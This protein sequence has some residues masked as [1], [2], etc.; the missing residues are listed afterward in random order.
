MV[1]M[2][3][4]DLFTIIPISSSYIYIYIYIYMDSGLK[5]FSIE[6]KNIRNGSDEEIMTVRS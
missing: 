1:I 3:A 5:G 2:Y 4:Y 6:P